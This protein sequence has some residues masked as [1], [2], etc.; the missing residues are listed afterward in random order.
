MNEVTNTYN[1]TVGFH[2][3]MPWASAA[4]G[5]LYPEN[6]FHRFRDMYI[7]PEGPFIVVM[8]RTGKGAWTDQA[9]AENKRIAEMNGFVRQEI[10]S[11]D[12]TFMHHFFTVPDESAEA[13]NQLIADIRAKGLADRYFEKPMDRF[14]RI[15]EE[16][17]ARTGG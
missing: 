7:D 13:I 6:E 1:A 8:T 3:I 17:M 14:K 9:E 10:D 12:E 16:I 15:C 11:F 2:P 5:F 4:S